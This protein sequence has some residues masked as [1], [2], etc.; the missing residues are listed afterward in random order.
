MKNYYDN[1]MIST[2]KECPRKFYFA[3]KRHWRLAGAAMPLIFGLAW[4]EAQNVIWG[5]YQF[6]TSDKITEDDLVESAMDEFNRVWAD[7]GLTP[8]GDM[9]PD[10]QEKVGQRNPMVA[11]EMLYAYLDKRRFI[12]ELA[13]IISVE[14]PFAVPIYPNRPDLWYIGRLDKN[15]EFN[16]EHLVIEHKTTSE[17]KIDGGFKNQFVDSFFPNSQVDGYIYAANMLDSKVKQVWVDAALVHKKVHDAFKFI[18]VVKNPEQ[19]DGWLFDTQE[20]IR[21][22]EEDT[23]KWEG[24]EQSGSTMQ[25]FPKNTNACQGKYGTCTYRSICTAYSNPEVHDLPEGFIEFVWAPFDVLH[26]EKIGLTK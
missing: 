22:I 5:G 3:H 24:E 18:P 17:Y 23:A 9:S 2:Y 7:E 13:K 1:T 6:V 12:L 20:W 8:W 15:V 16:G 14:Q 4:H 19:L 25:C 11:K 26:M 21:R 10:E